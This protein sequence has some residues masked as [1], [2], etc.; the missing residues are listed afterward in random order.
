MATHCAD[1]KIALTADERRYYEHRCEK[2]ENI[3]WGRIM[4]DR[5][6]FMTWEKAE[7]ATIDDDAYYLVHDNGHEWRD[8]DL[9]IQRGVLVRHKLEPS[10]VRGRPEWIAKIIRPSSLVGSPADER[11]VNHD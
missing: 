5:V 1:C 10:F 8:F 9:S 3:L 11:E 2:C 7:T 4:G 6:P